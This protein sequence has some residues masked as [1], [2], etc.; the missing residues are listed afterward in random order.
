MQSAMEAE[1]THTTVFA[2]PP[3]FLENDREPRHFPWERTN[4]HP[5][6]GRGIAACRGAQLP[7]HTGA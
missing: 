3:S 6:L 1:T 7:G 4:I 2:A 5:M